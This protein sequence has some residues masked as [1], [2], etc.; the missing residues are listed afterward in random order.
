MKKLILSILFIICL[1]IQ[2]SA[3]NP[4]VVVSGSSVVEET[5]CGTGSPELLFWWNMTDADVSDNVCVHAGGDS[6]ATANGGEISVGSGAITI[7]DTGDTG[8][9]YYAFTSA[10]A[11]IPQSDFTVEM[12]V[13]MSTIENQDGPELFLMGQAAYTDYHKFYFTGADIDLKYY[14]H[15]NSAQDN[16]KTFDVNVSA[17]ETLYI[18]LRCSTTNGPDLWVSTTGWPDSDSVGWVE[19]ANGCTAFNATADF[20]YVGN[21]GAHNLEGTIDNYFKLYNGWKTY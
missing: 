4:M 18:V 17:S 21:S 14:R 1:S 12:K 2:A 10:S 20:L 8:G 5:S 11:Q 9:D 6:S 3:W 16:I 19:G 7:T 13:N 15:V